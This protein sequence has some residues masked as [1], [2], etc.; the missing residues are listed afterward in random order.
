MKVLK[1]YADWC[2]PCK[3]LTRIIEDAADQITVQIENVDIDQ[4]LD[5]ARQYNIRGVPTM[6][7]LDDAGVEVKR[8]SGMMMEKELLDFLKG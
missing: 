2:Q 5:A 7:L 3:M 8:A 6:V 1:F 4:N